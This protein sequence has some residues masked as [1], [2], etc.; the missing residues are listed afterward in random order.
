MQKHWISWTI[1]SQWPLSL[2][3]CLDDNKFDGP[4]SVCNYLI[5]MYFSQA[6][7]GYT[8]RDS[9]IVAGS[10]ANYSF[11]CGGTLISRRF[12]VTAAHCITTRIRPV[13]VR[14]GVVS[15]ECIQN[16]TKIMSRILC[17][18]LGWALF[19]WSGGRRSKNCR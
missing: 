4:F 11:D 10:S 6:A 5:C 9:N 7:L 8:D 13:I 12:I 16:I 2:S 3:R 15:I 1:Y 17:S 14:M 19:K 18:L